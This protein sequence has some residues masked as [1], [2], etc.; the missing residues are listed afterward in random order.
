MKTGSPSTAE[1]QAK[2]GSNAAKEPTKYKVLI[3]NREW[4]QQN[5][6]E[7]T[8]EMEDAMQEHE[9]KGHTAVLISINGKNSREGKGR[10]ISWRKCTLSPTAQ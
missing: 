2:E 5:G 9:E 3:G 8:D 4:M 10:P 6:L 1:S 7:V